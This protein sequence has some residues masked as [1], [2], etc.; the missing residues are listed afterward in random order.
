[1]QPTPLSLPLSHAGERGND[2]NK[3]LNI[4]FLET[5][6]K[7]MKNFFNT[8]CPLMGEGEGLQETT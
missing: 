7:K 4:S 5:G 3:S 6:E 8:P 2:K 1:M